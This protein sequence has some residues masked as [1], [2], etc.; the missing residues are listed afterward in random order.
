MNKYLKSFLQRGIAFAGFGP[1]IT[2]IV[3]LFTSYSVENF[4]LN[5]KQI[6]IAMISTYI[7]AFVHA[8]VSVFNQIESWSISKSLFCHLGSLYLVYILC[9]LINSW[10]PFDINVILI[11]TAIFVATYFIIWL[12]VYF[13]VR[14]TSKKINSNLPKD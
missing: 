14:S 2:S 6:F 7:L 13:V 1:I 5:A 10:I 11:F 4:S 3:F 9:Y 8:G 12:S